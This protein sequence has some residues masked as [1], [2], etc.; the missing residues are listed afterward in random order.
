MQALSVPHVTSSDQ[1]LDSLGSDGSMEEEP[2]GD[3][4]EPPEDAE[5]L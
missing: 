2:H 3:A 5:D 1:D 4:E